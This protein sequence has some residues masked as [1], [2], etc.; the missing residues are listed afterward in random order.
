M[1]AINRRSFLTILAL[2]IA[3]LGVAISGCGFPAHINPPV[4]ERETQVIALLEARLHA[5]DLPG[6]PGLI[7]TVQPT[8]SMEPTLK[9]GD[10]I[11]V[12]SDKEGY[13]KIKRGEIVTY[14]A[15]WHKGPEPVTHRLISKDSYGWLL[16]GDA[17]PDVETKWRVT[18]K[19]YIGKVVAIYRVK[20]TAPIQ[21]KA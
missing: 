13:A 8:G 6:G 19:S 17:N 5:R 11:V 9:G 10:I 18:E 16:S 2:A 1:L 3:I 4:Y 12:D 7:F 14:M 20:P 21:P 15:E